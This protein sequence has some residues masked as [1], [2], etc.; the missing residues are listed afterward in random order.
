MAL[1]TFIIGFVSSLVMFPVMIEGGSM[2]PTL[3][4]GDVLYAN[5][6]E[7]RVGEIERGDV[8]VFVMEDGADG[9][10]VELSRGF[11]GG[12]DGGEYFFVKRVIGLPGEKVV[13]R[14]G[15]VEVDGVILDESYARGETWIDSFESADWG[16]GVY[17]VPEDEYFVL[18]DNRESSVDS[19]NFVRSF[20]P[21]EWVVGVGK[22]ELK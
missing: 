4:E 6:L 1:A 2:L 21:R 19:R 13:I 3:H 5:V 8:I 18:G 15:V 7:A 11:D 9:L 12:D 17:N 22:F 20:V 16:V 14:D 10:S